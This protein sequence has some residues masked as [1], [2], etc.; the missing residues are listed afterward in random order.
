MSSLNRPGPI[1]VENK[2]NS[3]NKNFALE[4]NFIRL[5]IE[6]H[7]GYISKL[8]DKINDMDVLAGKGAVPVVIDINHCDTWAHG[9]SEFRDE[10]GKFADAEVSIIEEGPIQA[11]LRVINRYNYSY[12]RQDFIIYHDRPDIEVHVQLD[13]REKYKMLKLSCPVNIDNASAVYE[14]P[15]GFISRPVN[16]EEEPGQQ[17]IDLSGKDGKRGGEYGLALLND[18]KY[19]FDVL[20]NEMRMTIANSSA[21]ADHYSIHSGTRDRLME[22]ID[23]GMQEFKYALVPHAGSWRE[24]G[25]VR[26]AFELNVRPQLV[27][28]TYHEGPLPSKFRGIEVFP[29]NIVAAVFKRAEDRGGFILRCYETWGRETTAEIEIPMLK[30]RWKACF[31]K[32]EIK[33]FFIPDNPDA[34]VSERN[35]TEM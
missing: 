8:Y 15:Y 2:N 31:S 22:Y 20:K 27:T 7:T 1:T 21:Y 16:G 23:Q 28:E 29:G 35:L 9:I 24:A 4:N 32:C 6:R 13:W 19:S 17:W 26:K 10:I 33:T 5:E 25:V 11:K 18:G 12:L 34:P 3:N 14:I 30:R